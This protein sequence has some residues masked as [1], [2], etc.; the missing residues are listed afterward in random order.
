MMSP[1]EKAEERVNK[2]FKLFED[3][4]GHWNILCA[5]YC[6]LAEINEILNVISENTIEPFVF[7]ID[8]WQEVKQEIEKL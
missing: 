5:K 1:K 3:N 2:Y 4:T 8:Y 7:D 6:A